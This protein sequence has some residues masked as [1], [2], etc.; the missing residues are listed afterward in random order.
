MAKVEQIKCPSCGAT[1]VSHISGINYQCDYCNST[2][3]LKQDN[4]RQIDFDIPKTTD[5]KPTSFKPIKFA[6][7][8]AVLI[9]IIS[10]GVSVFL[11]S[12]GKKSASGI[13]FLGEWQKPSID[14]YNCLVG[15]RGAIVWL[16]LKTQTNKLDSV[17][18]YLRLVDPVTKKI[19]SEKPLGKPK[20]WKELF[21]QSG[22]FDSEFFVSN[23]TAYN[24]SEN[25]GIQAY[26][27]YTGKR[28]FGNEWFEKKYALLKDGITKA[29]KEYYR[30]RL[31]ITSAAG[32]DLYYYFDSKLLLTKE[33]D[34]ARDKKER[35]FAEDI[36]LTRNK[37]SRLY[38]CNIQRRPSDDFV[39]DESYIEAFKSAGSSYSYVKGAKLISD[40]IYP[41]AVA[42]KKINGNLLFFYASSFSKK[43]T[44]ILA[45]VNKEGNFLW[46]NKDTT[47]KKIVEENTSDNLYI[48]Y[49]LGKDLIVVDV[50]NSRN[51]SIGI[52]L[53]TGK[54]QFVFGQSYSL[55]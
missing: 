52:N 49:R 50:Y 26:N 42:L 1:Q 14:N 35:T 34:E 41:M 51:Q 28:L 33:Q 16:V 17:K 19:V 25:G 48:K 46:K 7:I 44:G 15:S 47:F 40:S 21:N 31:K 4:P 20:A 54:T 27:L 45:L 53:K 12:A 22:L 6:I 24:V 43:G 36:Y 37:K 29:D 11:L 8:F 10:A 55:D 38:L 9:G 23:D 5:F 13:N 2:F 32:D 39:I 30:N 3:I 18:Y